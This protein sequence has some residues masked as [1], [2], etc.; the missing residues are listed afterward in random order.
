MF[1]L[2]S[3]AEF[4]LPGLLTVGN[5]TLSRCDIVFRI[6][7][8][9]SPAAEAMIGD[10]VIE[11][12]RNV[13]MTRINVPG[14]GRINAYNTHLCAFCPVDERETQLEQLREFVN[15][16]E[17]FLSGEDPIVLGGDFNLDIFRDNGA[18]RPLYDSIL[19]EGFTDAY[20]KYAEVAMD[21]L[22]VDLCEDPDNPDEHCTFG[23]SVLSEGSNARRIDYIFT[24]NF[25]PMLFAE[26]VFNPLIDPGEPTVSDH[27]GVLV[28][29]AL[30]GAEPLM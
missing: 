23:A 2:R 21:L 22:L 5:A 14:F 16:V 17:N 12:P 11:I 9:L 19:A 10:Q 7:K 6:V 28:R 15:D 1:E 3:A 4:T 25:G 13:L 8:L 20:A 29:V 18:E 24:E 26:V 27:S 30:P